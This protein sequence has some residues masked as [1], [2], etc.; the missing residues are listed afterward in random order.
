MIT[1]TRKL[2]KDASSGSA[3]A[4]GASATAAGGPSGGETMNNTKRISIR[5]RL[6]VKEVQEMDQNMPNTCKVYF[7]D[8]NVLSEFT[9][10]ITP[11]EGFWKDGR[12]KFV[13]SVPDEYNMTV[14]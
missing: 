11:D 12:F 14:I 1:L 13:A 4:S 8:P 6:L 9:L 2:K 10:Y 7:S 5:D 3:V